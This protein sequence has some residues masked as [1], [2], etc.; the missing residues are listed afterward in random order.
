MA[1][2]P[3]DW[4]KIAELLQ[5]RREPLQNLLNQPGT[6]WQAIGNLKD[7]TAV[8]KDSKGVTIPSIVG[9]GHGVG[10]AF[11]P[12]FGLDFS[13]PYFDI[14][15]WYLRLEIDGKSKDVL[16]PTDVNEMLNVREAESI[17]HLNQMLF[18]DGSG[19]IAKVVNIAVDK[20]YITIA[21]V[22]CNATTYPGAADRYFRRGM[23]V[24]TYT[25]AGEA[26]DVKIQITSVDATNHRLYGAWNTTVADDLIYLHLSKTNPEIVGFE[27]AISDTSVYGGVDPANAPVWKSVVYSLNNTALSSKTLI[28]FC[29]ELNAASTGAPITHIITTPAVA[30]AYADLFKNSISMLVQE[31]KKTADIGIGGFALTTP[32]SH[33]GKNGVVKIIADPMCVEGTM[34][35]I[36]GDTWYHYVVKP[37]E[38]LPGDND[39]GPFR[40]TMV[41]E[42]DAYMALGV[43]RHLVYTKVRSANGK[44]TGIKIA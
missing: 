40:H 29:A 2:N 15:D 44:I 37:F 10:T 21:P 36:A 32:Y 35:F 28:E 43:M 42:R 26:H 24:D 33:W 41:A 18:R 5:Y 27:G 1:L 8:L 20:S 17:W 4:S 38:W 22:Y 19:V 11:P 25:D 39:M 3:I 14:V 13:N 16:T 12:H 23:V 31:G 9:A 6:S 30:A 34:Y 7:P